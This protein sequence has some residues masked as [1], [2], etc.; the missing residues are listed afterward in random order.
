MKIK[1]G[2]KFRSPWNPRDY[3]EIIQS[4][5]E[6][7][8]LLEFRKRQFVDIANNTGRIISKKVPIEIIKNWF[9]NGDWVK[10]E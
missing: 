10:Y 7:D 2:M 8:K 5:Y 1:E 9:K 3:Y 6:V 4:I